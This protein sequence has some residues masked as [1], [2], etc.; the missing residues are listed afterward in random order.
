[1]PPVYCI[2]LAV[3]DNVVTMCADGIFLCDRCT[4]L[5]GISAFLREEVLMDRLFKKSLFRH[6]RFVLL[7]K[8]IYYVCMYVKIHFKVQNNT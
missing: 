5:M 6:L 3:Y 2:S 7:F 8:L 1:M 4:L